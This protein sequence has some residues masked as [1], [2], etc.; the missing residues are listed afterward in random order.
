MIS[1][2]ISKT[3]TPREREIVHL[4]WKGLKNHEIAKV[5][6]I[7]VNTVVAHRAK[8]MRKLEVR[9]LAQL[10]KVAIIGG[11]IQVERPLFPLQQK[12]RPEE[13]KV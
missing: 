9:N 7:S 4:V 8:V 13:S 3:L 12:P 2:Q 1:S 11:M 5:L 10:L 6:Q